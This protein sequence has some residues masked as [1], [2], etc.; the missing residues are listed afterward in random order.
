MSSDVEI[1][2]V[3]RSSQPPHR[4]R[5]LRANIAAGAERWGR[6]VKQAD[7]RGE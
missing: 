7:I 6:I 3:A 4:V 2:H 1:R 5:W